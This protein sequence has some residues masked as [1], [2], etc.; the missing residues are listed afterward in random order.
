MYD[1]Q[2][3]MIYGMHRSKNQETTT[4]KTMK[5]QLDIIICMFSYVWYCSLVRSSPFPTSL[6]C[7]CAFA[8]FFRLSL[9]KWSVRLEWLECR[10]VLSSYTGSIRP[11]L[12]HWNHRDYNV[13]ESLSFSSIS[14]PIP[15]IKLKLL[16]N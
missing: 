5:K 15:I 14:I 6:F 11:F 12:A 3:P 4:A 1:M 10:Y 8:V 9:I 7:R 16:F 2:Q 13:T